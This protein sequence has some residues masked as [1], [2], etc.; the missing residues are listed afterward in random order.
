MSYDSSK[1]EYIESKTQNVEFNNYED[2]NYIQFLYVDE[3]GTG[4]DTIELIFKAKELTSA[5][6]IQTMINNGIHSTIWTW[7]RM[8]GGDSAYDWGLF[9]DQDGAWCDVTTESFESIKSKWGTCLRTEN[10]FTE[11]TQYTNIFK[12]FLAN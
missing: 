2:E 8:G 7:K 11:N 4:T 12:N 9:V 10:N 3:S 6:Y 1:L 5:T